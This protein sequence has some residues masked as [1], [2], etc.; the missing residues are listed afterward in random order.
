MNIRQEVYKANDFELNTQQKV[1]VAQADGREGTQ[2]N[3]CK[4]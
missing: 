1:C 3:G 2:H 4:I